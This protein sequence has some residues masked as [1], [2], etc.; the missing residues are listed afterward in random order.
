VDSI[1]QKTN[2]NAFQ[3]IKVMLAALIS[4]ILLPFLGMCFVAACCRR[5][6]KK[7]RARALK[8]TVY[9]N[10]LRESFPGL[11]SRDKLKHKNSTGSKT[12]PQPP[13]PIEM[14]RIEPSASQ[15]VSTVN[16][17]A[18]QSG[19]ID[20][21]DVVVDIKTAS[22]KDTDIENQPR[23]PEYMAQPDAVFYSVFGKTWTETSSPDSYV[24][25]KDSYIG[26]QFSLPS[27]FAGKMNIS[28][29]LQDLLLEKEVLKQDVLL[30]LKSGELFF[31]T[32]KARTPKEYQLLFY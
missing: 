12:D 28:L 17:S 8:S 20:V 31:N 4:G 7:K 16:S 1:F 23:T 27:G 6:K 32:Q 19:D 9:E 14:T 30:N 21:V 15:K 2:A 3:D 29:D 5:C 22:S 13:V 24:V 10:P 18:A 25:Q 26:L 11:F